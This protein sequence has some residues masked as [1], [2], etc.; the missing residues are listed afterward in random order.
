M[1]VLNTLVF[2]IVSNH[3]EVS[4]REQIPFFLAG[5]GGGG[6]AQNTC[7]FAG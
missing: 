4:L 1:P 2:N 7:A 5:G 3:L 6:G